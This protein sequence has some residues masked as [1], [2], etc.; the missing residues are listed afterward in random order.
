M[1]GFEATFLSQGPTRLGFSEPTAHGLASTSAGGDTNVIAFKRCLPL[2]KVQ[3]SKSIVVECEIKVYSKEPRPMPTG[4]SFSKYMDEARRSNLFTDV[5]LVA[6]GQEFKAH[7]VVLASQSQ[8]FKARFSRPW[9]SPAPADGSSGE[10]VEMTDVSAVVMEAMLSY[11]Y[12]GK[13]TDIGE[14]AEQLLPAA[15]EYGLAD[16]RKMCEEELIQSLTTNTVIS[17]LLHAA[18]HNAP[19]LKEAC[20]EFVV[21]NTAAVKQSEGW[22]EL[23]NDQTHRDLWVELLETIVEKSLVN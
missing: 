21:Y 14:I 7:K 2:S 19:T 10:R 9:V 6:D 5:T 12:T 8:F 23:K 22:N 16:L 17:T 20:I 3:D 15:E 4:F 11:M 1:S 18:A 13:V